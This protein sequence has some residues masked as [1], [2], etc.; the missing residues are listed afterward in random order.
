M[1]KVPFYYRIKIDTILFCDNNAFNRKRFVIRYLID[2]AYH[3]LCRSI[4]KDMQEIF[5]SRYECIHILK[6]SIIFI[7]DENGFIIFIL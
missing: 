4:D 1:F 3:V 6:L 5:H 7:V 2:Y